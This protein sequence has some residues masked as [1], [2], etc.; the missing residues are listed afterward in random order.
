M[1]A[2]LIQVTT[3]HKISGTVAASLVSIKLNICYTYLFQMQ[4]IN[5]NCAS[6]SS[7]S[8]FPDTRANDGL[9]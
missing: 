7:G 3:I 6:L 2:G 4:E 5:Q 9:V 1:E 8:K